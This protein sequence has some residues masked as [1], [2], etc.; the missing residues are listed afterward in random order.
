MAL[1]DIDAA[2]QQL[3][4]ALKRDPNHKGAL[5]LMYLRRSDLDEEHKE[6]NLGE[7]SRPRKGWV[8]S[9]QGLLLAAKSAWKRGARK[10]AVGYAAE[11][12]KLAPNLDEVFLSYTGML[13]D[14]GEYEWVAALT[15]PRLRQGETRSRPFMNFARALHAMGLKDEAVNTCRRA[16]A[17][18]TLTREEQTAFQQALDEWTGRFA[19]GE[20]DAELHPGGTSLRR[21]IYDVRD[22]KAQVMVFES[23]MGMPQRRKLPVAFKTPKTEFDF[24]LEQRNA[25]DDPEQHG[26][27]TFTISEVEPEKLPTEAVALELLLDK[28]GKLVVGARQGDRKL[29]VRWSLYPPPRHVTGEP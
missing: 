20:V 6:L 5:E 3:H 22:G 13:G 17:E 18:L 9:W 7:Y 4:V 14:S 1:Q 10:D 26:L 19:R 23:G 29:A 15:K 16:L 21:S 24:T 27:G 25:M 12:Y 11:A 2:W 28:G 8:G